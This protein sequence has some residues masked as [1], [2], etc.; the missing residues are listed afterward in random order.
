[1]TRRGAVPVGLAVLLC[2]VAIAA[3]GCGGGGGSDSIV[4]YNGQHLALTRALISAFEKET[5]ISVRTRTSDGVVLAGLI[6]QEGS[7]SP[8]DVFMTENS[9]ELMNLEEKGRLA[10]LDPSIL[11]A[12]PAADSSPTGRWAGVSLRVGSLAYDPSL[13][14]RSK[15]PG[16]ILDLAKP[17]WKGKVAVAPT[18]SDFPPVVGAIIATRGEKAAARWLAG[19]KRNAQ[20]YQDAEAVV[21]AVNRGDVAAGLVNSYYWYRLR[22]EEG[23]DR[24][25]STLHYFPSSDVG[26]VVNV[27]GA[28]VLK[29]SH[30]RK[31]AE[32]FIAFLLSRTGQQVIASGDAYEYPARPGVPANK[33]LPPLATVPHANVGVVRLGDDSVA[34]RL[35]T[36]SG[37]GT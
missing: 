36:G 21:A 27:A 9:P 6:L 4:L 12:V 1:V 3:A 26:S 37:F 11:R 34:A 15:L 28:A 18:D 8:A 10:Q 16:S 14:P 31:E 30:H 23:A 19:L 13:L 32:R 17:E 20:V 22:R 33:A 25:H 7:A 29:S 5:G 24:M 2:A 35:I